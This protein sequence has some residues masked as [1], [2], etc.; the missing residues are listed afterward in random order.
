MEGFC[1]E[2]L[3]R[4]VTGQSAIAKRGFF[5]GL[6]VWNLQKNSQTLG[7]FAPDEAKLLLI[8]SPWILFSS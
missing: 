6:V 5:G 2:S 7:F 4:L 8:N 3:L 1:L